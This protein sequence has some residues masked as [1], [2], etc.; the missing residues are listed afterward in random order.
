[1]DVTSQRLPTLFGVRHVG[2]SLLVGIVFS[3]LAGG[4]LGLATAGPE[5]IGPEN[6]GAVQPGLP[7]V[8][9]AWSYEIQRE[10]RP[11]ERILLTILEP[12]TVRDATGARILAMPVEVRSLTS[13]GPVIIHR[14]G[15]GG[16][17]VNSET[18][19]HTRDHTQSLP[20]YGSLMETV[21][22]VTN[23]T[24]SE[25]AER[26]SCLVLHALQGQA[27]EGT[28]RPFTAC[29]A[30]D[31]IALLD[32]AFRADGLD[33]VADQPAA[34]VVAEDADVRA[35]FAPDLPYV[36]RLE[37][38]AADR[39]TARYT[40][41]GFT[42][43]AGAV[44][45]PSVADAKTLPKFEASPLAHG[46]IDD[47]VAVTHPYRL[48][49]AFEL[50]RRDPHD[51]RVADFLQRHPKATLTYAAYLEWENSKFQA[52]REWS[53]ALGDGD[54]LL[55]FCVTSNVAVN[56]TAAADDPLKPI[57]LATT[58]SQKRTPDERFNP[59]QCREAPSNR[60]GESPGNTPTLAQLWQR[61]NAYTGKAASEPRAYGL[62]YV[63]ADEPC[64]SGAYVFEVGQL[65][66]ST[67]K[68]GPDATTESGRRRE[69]LHLD[70]SGRATSL[71]YYDERRSSGPAIS[72]QPL[73]APPEP[74]V[75][76]APT[77]AFPVGRHAAEVGLAGLFAGIAYW[78]WPTLRHGI[79]GLLH[80]S[81]EPLG[82][83]MRAQ[84]HELIGKEPGLHFQ[85]IMRRLGVK[86][87]S[88]GHHLVVL[89]DAGLIVE[90]V[91]P[92]FTCYFR[93]GD[94]D[95]RIMAGAPALKSAGSRR[96]LETLCTMPRSTLGEVARLSGFAPAT[97]HYHAHRLA[98]AG[99]VE[100]ERE[101]SAM[102]LRASAVA[103]SA[104]AL[105]RAPVP[106]T[107]SP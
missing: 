28:M 69:M 2:F 98:A 85:A 62:R 35:W 92:G 96:V 100:V 95:R 61:W 26:A 71:Q 20:G 67:V 87:S 45:M 47:S 54:D 65:E 88:L 64:I 75:P 6:P 107:T 56:P 84:I 105:P 89:R 17:I 66:S 63:C 24:S 52:N 68:P 37:V 91:S 70:E 32:H 42:R 78:L 12:Q 93:R 48:T 8:G 22:T 51:T 11:S 101:G 57:R 60:T 43:G 38:G 103:T 33:L 49:D 39:P 106:L 86:R 41:D 34:R 83:P 30:P 31:G 97:V 53:L 44:P 18:T 76:L 40:L 90:Q 10:G 1:M 50:A 81:K 25:A 5:S 94:V 14:V 13:P 3:G 7:R 4:F 80:R 55:R 46:L 23:F 9:D 16:L 73:S 29:R 58:N 99:L 19:I 77:W 82:H 104:L 79:W 102:F 15:P 21:F 59:G 74:A 36:V 27:V 72:P